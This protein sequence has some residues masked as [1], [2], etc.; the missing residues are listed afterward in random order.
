VHAHSHCNQC[1]LLTDGAV[2]CVAQVGWGA[3]RPPRAA[4]Q[5]LRIQ[6]AGCR[7]VLLH[8]VTSCPFRD[9]LEATPKELVEGGLYTHHHGLSHSARALSYTHSPHCSR[10][11]C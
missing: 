10:A 3:R 2:L 1:T 7:I 4:R 6:K 11:L 8:D 9:A 5:V